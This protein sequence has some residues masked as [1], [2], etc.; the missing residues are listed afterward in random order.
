MNIIEIIFVLTGII[1]SIFLTWRF[2]SGP[3]DDARK[4]LNKQARN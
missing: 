3:E 1:I 4:A 2:S